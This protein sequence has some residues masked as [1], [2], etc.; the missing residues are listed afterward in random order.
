M[1]TIRELVP[2]GM[3]H[4]EKDQVVNYEEFEQYER[5]SQIVKD[6]LEKG[7]KSLGTLGGGNH[8]IEIQKGSDG[9]IWI[10]IHS[11]SR[12][13]GFTVANYYAKLAK[14][15]NAK[16]YTTVPLDHDLAFLPMD[17]IEGKQYMTDQ[18]FCI[19]FAYRNRRLMLD[20]VQL[21]FIQEFGS[22]EFDKEINK[23]HNFATY[24]NHYGKNIVVHRKGATRA[25]LD[26]IGMI[27]G[28]QG[29]SS[30]IVKGKGNDESFRS[31]SH[32]AG[33]KMGRSFAR[34]NL[35][36]ETEKKMLDDL[37]VVHSIRNVSDLDE[38][39]S[40]YKDIKDVMANQTDLVE[41]VVELKPLAVI[42]SSD[43]GVD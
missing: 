24:E 15:I 5:I 36:L 23:P 28:S 10:M 21:A 32:G 8:F 6:Q 27:P 34:K 35:S 33:R 20:R 14:E 26:E 42:K 40:A 1:G 9:F 2:V 19:E 43:G 17:S 38:A 12:N 30:Y 7:R 25:F 11:G 13:L 16:Y 18:E 3:E 41:I 31:C 4:Q 39:P 29:T 37:G 22:V